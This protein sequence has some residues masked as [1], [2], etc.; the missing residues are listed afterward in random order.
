[1]VNVVSK[2]NLGDVIGKSVKVFLKQ[3]ANDSAAF[4][5]KVTGHNAAYEGQ[6]KYS[7]IGYDDEGNNLTIDLE[8]ID[9]ISF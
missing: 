9:F 6:V 2:A 5:F 4:F 3:R 7:L 1:M 8:D